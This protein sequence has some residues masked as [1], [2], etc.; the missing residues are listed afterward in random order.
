[1][2]QI[3]LMSRTPIYEQLIDQTEKLI[4]AGI[5]NPLDKMPSV[6]SLSSKLS[7]NPNTIQRAYTD[8]CNMGILVSM[9]GRGCYVTKDAPEIIRRDALKK[10]EPLD[11]IVGELKLAG[12]DLE[13]I[14]EHIK[15]T[16]NNM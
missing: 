7:V 14:I 4:L 11:Q 1:M 13:Q 9:A 5:L 10:F 3:D 6:R 2:F 15:E 8:M 12:I 16:Y